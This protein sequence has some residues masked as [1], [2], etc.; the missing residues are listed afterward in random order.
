METPQNSEL[1][2]IIRWHTTGKQNMT[3]PEMIIFLADLIEPGRNYTDLE[4]IRKVAFLNL[5][6]AMAISCEKIIELVKKKNQ[7][8]CLYTLQCFDYYKTKSINTN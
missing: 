7:K 3:K 6:K 2:N 1:F 5:E 8:L 4:I